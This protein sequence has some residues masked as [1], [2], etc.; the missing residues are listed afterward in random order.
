MYQV[1]I[2]RC[3][4]FEIIYAIF[5]IFTKKADIWQDSVYWLVET[6]AVWVG[7]VCTN[8]FLIPAQENWCIHLCPKCCSS[9]VSILP[10]GWVIWP[11]R[12]LYIG[13]WQQET[14]C[15]Q[16]TIFARWVK[17]RCSIYILTVIL[18]QIADFGMSRDLQDADYYVSTGGKIPLKWTAPEALYFKKYSTASDVWSYGCVLYEIWSLGTKPYQGIENAEV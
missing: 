8:Q 17:I 5:A 18:F 3:S 11:A 13:I 10:W 16:A 2:R 4:R 14:F 1:K 15:W 7:L 9:T 6:T 12:A